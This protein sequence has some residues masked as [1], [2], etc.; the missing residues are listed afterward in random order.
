MPFT[1]QNVTRYKFQLWEWQWVVSVVWG[2]LEKKFIPCNDYMCVCVLLCF[3]CKMMSSSIITPPCKL[4]LVIGW[5]WSFSSSSLPSSWWLP[6]IHR[7][8][9]V[10]LERTFSRV[11]VVRCCESYK[12]KK[13]EF[14]QHNAC[15]TEVVHFFLLHR[16]LKHHALKSR[17]M[18]Q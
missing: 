12:I 1:K 13:K 15:I 8:E 18:L 14:N 16:K 2:V 6:A 10:F 11:V 7:V 5:I 9:L 17:L 4:S 3:L